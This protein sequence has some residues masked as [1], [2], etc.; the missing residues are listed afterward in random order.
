MD[1]DCL[2]GPHGLDLLCG[3]PRLSNRSSKRTTKTKSGKN[4]CSFR[5]DE[6]DL[7]GALEGEVAVVAQIAQRYLGFCT[8][9][10]IDTKMTHDAHRDRGGW[11]D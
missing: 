11:G 2:L 5:R 9:N 1:L 3:L 7:V 8:Y 10:G 4:D 6:A